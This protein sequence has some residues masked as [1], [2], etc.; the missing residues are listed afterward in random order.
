MVSRRETRAICAQIC[1]QM[2]DQLLKVRT[3][4]VR[5]R[6]GSGGREV[7]WDHCGVSLHPPLPTPP[8][9]PWTLPPAETNPSQLQSSSSDRLR[10]LRFIGW[11]RRGA[12]MVLARSLHPI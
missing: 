1:F 2:G 10:L 9:H 3:E 5:V 7:S 4:H 11:G 12:M 6:D 8:P